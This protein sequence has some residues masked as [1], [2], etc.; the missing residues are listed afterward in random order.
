MEQTQQGSFVV[1]QEEM[2]VLRQALFVTL[3]HG[4]A[5][6]RGDEHTI[7]GHELDEFQQLMWEI[8]ELNGHNEEIR[9]LLTQQ[10]DELSAVSLAELE[11]RS[12]RLRDV[13]G[14]AERYGVDVPPR[15]LEVLRS[16]T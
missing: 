9:R 13:A 11:K 4:D 10:I 6:F 12:V 2:H 5:V 16:Q 14:S 3:H 1:T 7:T 15:L 8:D